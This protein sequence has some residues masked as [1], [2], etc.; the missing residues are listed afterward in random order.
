MNNL[1]PFESIVDKIRDNTISQ[2]SKAVYISSTCRFLT[3]LIENKPDLVCEEFKDFI[4]LNGTIQ[5]KRI[6]EYISDS[7]RNPDPIHFERLSIWL[8]C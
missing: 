2:S 8:I 4:L 6:V 3:W 1:E 7:I 5:K